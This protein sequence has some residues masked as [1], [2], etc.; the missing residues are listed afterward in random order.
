MGT[1]FLIGFVYCM[2][3]I[4]VRENMNEDGDWLLTIA[5]I[6]LWP[7]FFIPLIIKQMIK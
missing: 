7:I 5:W 6:L 1:Y 3:N 2:I 4:L